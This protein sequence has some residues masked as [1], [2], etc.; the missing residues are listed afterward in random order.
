MQVTSSPRRTRST[1][2]T[3]L[4]PKENLLSTPSNRGANI[5]WG[6][7]EQ[8]PRGTAQG[9]G[10]LGAESSQMS[11]TILAQAQREETGTKPRTNSEVGGTER[12]HLF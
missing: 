3:D 1:A 9:D 10:V 7:G 12:E 6:E 2:S 5:Y 4:Q 8:N 11:G